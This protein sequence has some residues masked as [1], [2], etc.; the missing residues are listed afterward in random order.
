MAFCFLGWKMTRESFGLALLPNWKD[1]TVGVT[2]QILSLILQ[3]PRTIDKDT[4]WVAICEIISA[5]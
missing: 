1:S 3:Y 5:T 4:F 2:D